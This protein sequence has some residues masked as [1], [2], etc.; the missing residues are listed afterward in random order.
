MR[1]VVS[2]R[3]PHSVPVEV[4]FMSDHRY[5]VL[6]IVD[7]ATLLSEYPD[8]SKDADTPTPI[9]GR[10][11]YVLSPGDAGQVGRN[12]SQ[13]F[14]G[15]SVGDDLHLRETALALRAEVSVLFIRFAL[16]DAGIVSPIEAQI[17]D[18]DALIPNFDD[19]L[20]PMPQSMKDHFWHS[21]VLAAGK[22]TCTA[23]LAVLDRDGAVLGYFRWEVSVE[24]A[25]D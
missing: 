2:G 9:D 8:A 10:Y 20:Q 18:F 13:L 5:D 17:R 12:D 4:V 15:L 6:A 19:L 24:I 11:I 14:A 7:A 21:K 16:N 22:T 3:P 25:G 23:D 1:A